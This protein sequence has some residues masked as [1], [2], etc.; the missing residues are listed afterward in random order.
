MGG[1]GHPWEKAREA[2]LKRASSWGW[3]AGR[4]KVGLGYQF[5]SLLIFQSPVQLPGPP[6]FLLSFCP[7]LTIWTGSRIAPTLGHGFA[8]PHVRGG[9]TPIV[10][11]ETEVWGRE[12]VHWATWSANG[13][14]A[15]TRV[16][17]LFSCR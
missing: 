1:L 5:P 16:F 17:C 12:A 11:Q 7:H 13:P 15:L 14:Q 8:W 6:S 3:T 10:R 2:E 9:L 4:Q